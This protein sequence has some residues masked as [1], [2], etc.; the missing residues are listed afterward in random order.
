MTELGLWDMENATVSGGHVPAEVFDEKEGSAWMWH[1]ME[2]SLGWVRQCCH[3]PASTRQLLQMGALTTPV[4][5]FPKQSRASH[6]LMPQHADSS[7]SV[8]SRAARG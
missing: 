2:Q 4:W 7:S 5:A 6:G 8:S 3:V 1:P